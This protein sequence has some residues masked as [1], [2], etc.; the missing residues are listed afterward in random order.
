[1]C[2]LICEFYRKLCVLLSYVISIHK[3]KYTHDFNQSLF[4]P[5]NLF[6]FCQVTD[7][8]CLF[9][10]HPYYLTY[11]ILPSWWRMRWC[12][13]RGIYTA[14]VSVPYLSNLIKALHLFFFPLFLFRS[15]QINFTLLHPKEDG[16]LQI[17]TSITIRLVATIANSAIRLNILSKMDKL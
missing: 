15:Q 5:L 12:M 13:Q 8:F 9:F 11:S 14:S 2:S 3:Q 7:K 1:M 10:I 16:K 6:S 4:C 17:Q